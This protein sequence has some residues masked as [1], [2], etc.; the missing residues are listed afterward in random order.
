MSDPED[1]LRS[2]HDCV[3]ESWECT[4]GKI[5]PIALVFFLFT[6]IVYIIS[7]TLMKAMIPF[8]TGFSSL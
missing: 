5:L 4:R 3:R 6:G 8:W 1:D 7:Y 2:G